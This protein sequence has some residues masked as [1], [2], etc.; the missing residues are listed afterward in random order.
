MTPALEAELRR[1]AE[2]LFSAEFALRRERD[3][4]KRLVP[5]AAQAQILREARRFNVASCGRRIG[6]ALSVDTPIPTPQGWRVMGDLQ[7]GDEVFDDLGWPCHVTS[8]TP[9]MVDHQCYRIEFSDRTFLIADAEHQWLTYD[10]RARKALAD[11]RRHTVPS[12][13][14]TEQIRQ[15]L[16]LPT[17][18]SNHAIQTAKPLCYPERELPLDSYLL[19]VWLGDGSSRSAMVAT[20]DQEILDAFAGAG[21]RYK[22]CGQYDYYITR[23]ERRYT[24]QGSVNSESLLARLRELDVLGN[25]H[26]PRMYLEAAPAQRFDLLAGLMD[27]DG[28]VS[29]KGGQCSFANSNLR[30]IADVQELL[31]GLGFK[32]TLHTKPKPIAQPHVDVSYELTFTPDRQVF[33]LER[34][35]ERWNRRK[36]FSNLRR[37]RYVRSVTPVQSVPVKCIQVDSLSRLY[38]A[39]EACIVTHNT[40]LA[41]DRLVETSY[42]ERAPAAYWAPTY[43]MLADTWAHLV[44]VLKPV[45]VKV[46]VQEKRLEVKGGGIIDCWSFEAPDA[47]RGRKYKRAVIDEAA[48]SPG[49]KAAWEAAIR[50]TLTDLRGDGWFLSTP[51][52][53]SDFW[54]LYQMGLD[55]AEP[56]W[57]CWQ[58]PTS[59]NPFIDLDEIESARRM[60]PEDIFA[61]EYLASFIADSGA[62]F[63]RILEAAT[64]VRQEVGEE[65]HEYVIGCDWAKYQDFS[66]FTVIDTRTRELVLLARYNRLEYQYQL[67][68]LLSLCQLFCPVVVASEETG[69]TALAEQIR[70]L[71][72]FDRKKNRRVTIPLRNFQTTN[73]SKGEIIQALALAFER[74]DIRVLDDPVLIGELQAF[75]FERS[76]AGNLKYAAP[77]GFHDDCVMSLAIGWNEA[78]RFSMAESLTPREVVRRKRAA[79]GYSEEAI[80]RVRLADP[81]GAAYVELSDQYHTSHWVKAS[82]RRTEWGIGSANDEYEVER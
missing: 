65:F 80:A 44:E 15:T 43:K 76:D 45:T 57:A 35:A 14:T 30:L 31:R 77:A 75:R 39:G 71:E 6:K 74:K 24:Q 17:G 62:V 36:G 66:V 69:N 23:G 34:K 58:M 29:A 60:L 42:V 41:V 48:H 46:S 40:E 47:C 10:K 3:P 27:T 33:R 38:V 1:Q 50:P 16:R 4:V 20:A 26:I 22:H 49:L 28:T 78:K 61:Q 54:Q 7:I 67:E 51:N 21:F 8:A 32:P 59:A 64:A 68:R 56:E 13:V 53:M 9:I 52:G 2:L 70:R 63:R 81:V 25:K 11:P 73:A 19:G 82:K 18:E 55:P 72:Y 79:A 12:V 5:H 37:L